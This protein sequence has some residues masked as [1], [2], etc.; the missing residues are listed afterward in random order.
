MKQSF[1]F[2]YSQN[3]FLTHDLPVLSA[4]DIR[5]FWLRRRRVIHTSRERVQLGGGKS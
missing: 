5:T 4:A 2:T 1:D 3:V